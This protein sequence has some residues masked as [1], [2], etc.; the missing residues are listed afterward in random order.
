MK[1]KCVFKDL[2]FFPTVMFDFPHSTV[3]ILYISLMIYV[4]GKAQCQC[5]FHFQPSARF[6]RIHFSGMVL[7]FFCDFS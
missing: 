4:P 7:L 6:L 3:F 5:H 1:S 2:C